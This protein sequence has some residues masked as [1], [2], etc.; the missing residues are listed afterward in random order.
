M[1][2]VYEVDPSGDVVIILR[3]P[4]APFAEAATEAEPADATEALAV[5]GDPAEDAPAPAAAADLQS[6]SHP[7]KTKKHKKKKRSRSFL[8]LSQVFSGFA[9]PKLNQSSKQ[10]PSQ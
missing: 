10:K 9:S 2:E 6:T 3:N 1:E 5:D 8:F 4:G 7:G